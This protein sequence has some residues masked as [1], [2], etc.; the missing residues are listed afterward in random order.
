MGFFDNFLRYFFPKNTE[1]PT[2]RQSETRRPSSPETASQSKA[3]RPSI[4]ETAGQSETPRPSLPET[5]PGGLRN[6]DVASFSY[7]VEPMTDTAIICAFDPE[8]LAH[9]VDPVNEE[10]WV[11]DF[12]TTPEV[13]NGVIVMLATFADGFYKTRLTNQDLTDEERHFV[14]YVLPELGLHIVSGHL[15]IGAAEEMPA[16]TEFSTSSMREAISGDQ[17]F[18]L[19]NGDYT[20]RVYGLDLDNF[21]DEFTDEEKQMAVNLPQ[22]VM[23]I[24]P[25]K[26]K[27]PRLT[28]EPSAFGDPDAKYVFRGKK[29]KAATEKVMIAEGTSLADKTV[30]FT[31]KL[32]KFTRKQAEEAAKKQGATVGSSIT[33]KT[34]ILVIG[35]A[36]GSKATKARALGVQ[37]LTEDQWLELIGR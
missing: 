22:L 26:A 2:A 33:A 16:G 13:K 29:T 7:E 20:V 14:K 28:Q 9:R 11:M 21:D 37:I 8:A 30:V 34:D 10:W 24:F 5:A 15:Y 17:L 18:S 32:T 12:H 25:G 19:K 4:P 3:P 27:I 36:P 35:E 23:Q 6:L 31:G 1:S